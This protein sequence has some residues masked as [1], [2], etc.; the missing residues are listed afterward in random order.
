MA[1]FRNAALLPAPKEC[2][3]LYTKEILDYVRHVQGY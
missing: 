3:I 1:V 2:L